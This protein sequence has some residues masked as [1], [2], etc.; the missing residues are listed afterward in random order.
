MELVR[1]GIIGPVREVHAWSIRPIWP[2]GRAAIKERRKNAGKP[3]P[4]PLK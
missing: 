3:V 1:A 4:E 2:Q